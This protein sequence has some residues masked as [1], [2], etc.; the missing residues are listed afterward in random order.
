[1]LSFILI[2]IHE[3]FLCYCELFLSDNFSLLLQTSP[4]YYKLLPLNF[5]LLKKFLMRYD[6]K[7]L[8]LWQHMPKT[9]TS[10]IISMYLKYWFI[11]NK[12]LPILYQL[13]DLQHA[14]VDASLKLCFSE[15]QIGEWPLTY[16]L[17]TRMHP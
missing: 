15:L 5:S 4:S 16:L 3:N 9:T 2:L 6:N 12:F 1:M 11:C 8:P 13:S 14:L 7:L 10:F 17:Y